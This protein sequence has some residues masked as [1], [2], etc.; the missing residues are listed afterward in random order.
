MLVF[1]N[2]RYRAHGLKKNNFLILTYWLNFNVPKYAP[3]KILLFLKFRIW[4]N[5]R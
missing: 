2:D 3:H 4:F 5:S 1:F